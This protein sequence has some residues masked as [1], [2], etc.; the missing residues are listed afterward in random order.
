MNIIAICFS[1]FCTSF[2]PETSIE[3]LKPHSGITEFYQPVLTDEL[4]A[5]R[6]EKEFN[7]E[8]S[9]ISKTMIIRDAT[10]NC[11]LKKDAST[12]TRNTKNPSR[13]T[14]S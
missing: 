12:K 3:N 1:I 9:K 5:E 14:R 11:Q 10:V 6:M 13:R 4:F 2:S 8:K 7:F